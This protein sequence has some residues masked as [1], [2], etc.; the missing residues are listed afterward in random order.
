MDCYI[1]FS[2]EEPIMI[3]RSLEDHTKTFEEIYPEPEIRK[4]DKKS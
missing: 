3:D 1:N 4:I 2:T